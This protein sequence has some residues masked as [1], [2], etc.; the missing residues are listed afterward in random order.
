VRALWEGLWRWLA[1]LG[2]REVGC[3]LGRHT[4][5]GSRVLARF[6]QDACEVCGRVFDVGA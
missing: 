1:G 6:R 4:P 2:R 3:R 5:M